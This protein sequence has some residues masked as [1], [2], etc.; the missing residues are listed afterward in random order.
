MSNNSKQSLKKKLLLYLCTVI[1]GSSAIFSFYSQASADNCDPQVIKKGEGCF[2][3]QVKSGNFS[4]PIY[5]YVP[6]KLSENTKVLFAMHGKKRNAQDYRNDWKSIYNN[7]NNEHNNFIL[8]APQ[9]EQKWFPKAA[10]YNLGNMFTEDLNILNPRN[11]W[12]FTE[13][14]N[15]FTFVKR[16][17]QVK[18]NNYYIYGHSAGAQFVHRMVIFM[19]DAHLEKAV[20]AEAGSYIIPDENS[21]YPC[22]LK[23]LTGESLPS[24]NLKKA[25]TIPMTIILGTKDNKVLS[26][27]HDSY[28]CAAQQGNNRLARGEYFYNQVKNITHQRKEDF[29]WTLKEVT[30][31]H[32][33]ANTNPPIEDPMLVSCAALEFF[34]KLTSVNCK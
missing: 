29:N 24:V 28:A 11:K 7:N 8:L 32:I 19:P 26:S 17:T 15:I 34:P 21:E 1:I 30:A 22:G 6:E 3:Y 27:E 14:E 20:A 9:F 12:A 25:F 23:K 33:V 31:T 4:I 18:A 2:L 5:Y 16:S 13:I 10:G